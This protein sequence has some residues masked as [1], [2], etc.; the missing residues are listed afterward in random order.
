[1]LYA[2]QPLGAET[3]DKCWLCLDL[4]D[5]VFL[6]SI[7]CYIFTGKKKQNKKPSCSRKLLSLSKAWPQK[8]LFNFQISFCNLI[9]TVLTTEAWVMDQYRVV[10]EKWFMIDSS[11]A[12]TFQMFSPSSSLPRKPLYFILESSNLCI[13]LPLCAFSIPPKSISLSRTGRCMQP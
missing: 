3:P 10:K 13:V 2:P 8:V 1:M 12:L 5:I 4:T 9:A 11:P 6:S 7:A